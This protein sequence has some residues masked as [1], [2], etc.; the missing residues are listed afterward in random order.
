MAAAMLCPPSG[1]GAAMGAMLMSGPVAETHAVHDESSSSHGHDH[2]HAHAESNQQPHDHSDAA[3]AQ[4]KCNMCA[5]FCSLTPMPIG[6]AVFLPS[7]GVA[8]APSSL[9]AVEP[10]SFVPGGLERPPRSI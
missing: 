4:G 1:S 6:Q 2:A 10:L 3:S 9:F 8:T 5:A 7:A